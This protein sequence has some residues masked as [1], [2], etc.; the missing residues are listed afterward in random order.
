[1]I[2]PFGAR[3]LLLPPAAE[4]AVELDVVEHLV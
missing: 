2:R 4:G 1:M 3:L